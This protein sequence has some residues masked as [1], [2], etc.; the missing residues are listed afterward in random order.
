MAR[1]QHGTARH[2]VAAV[3]A[4]YSLEGT[5]DA[6]LAGVLDAL[7]PDMETD[8]GAYAFVCRIHDGRLD[9][10][11]GYA[12]RDLDPGFAAVVAELNRTAPEAF[13][14]LLER[15][16]VMTGAFTDLVGPLFQT[17]LDEHAGPHQVF[18]ALEIFA[19]DGEGW[20]VNV[21]APAR[22]RVHAP[23]RVRGIWKRIGFHVA[24][25]LRLR[26]RL[27]TVGDRES[28][29]FA[30]DGKLLHAEGELRDDLRGRDALSDAVRSMERA[31]TKAER[32]QPDRALELWK[33]L[34][35]G[36][37]SLVDSGTSGGRR[38]VAAHRNAPAVKDPR[39]LTPRE[40]IVLHYASRGASNKEVAFALGLAESTIAAAVSRIVRK[41]GCRRRSD[42]PAFARVEQAERGEMAV[43]GE[44]IDLLVL[45]GG[46][47]SALADELT[48]AER[49]VAAAV[50]EGKSNLEIARARGRS[51]RTVANQIRG[52]FE[53]LKLR[54]RSQLVKALTG[55]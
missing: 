21:V 54:G 4:A 22:R 6:W 27:A 33:G 19:Q 9:L 30:P 51:P 46:G 24:A 23:P 1:S 29:A 20:G 34:V 38:Y 16:V 52:I 10:G 48:D 41:L 15:N 31:R 37:W 25:G 32:A 3:E 44:R 40:R 12:E 18:D 39:A 5:D 26:R 14:G 13:F 45:P 28:A 35:A 36:E 55:G 43:A 11:H 2:A 53:K 47:R 8:G 7:R 50:V 42:L 49:A 17:H